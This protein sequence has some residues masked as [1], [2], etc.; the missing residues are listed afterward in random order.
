MGII[1]RVITAFKKIGLELNDAD[2]NVELV[3]QRTLQKFYRTKNNVLGYQKGN[4]VYIDN[5]YN[6]E[7]VVY[8]LAHELAHIWQVKNGLVK[9]LNRIDYWEGFADWVA[10]KIC[11][12]LGYS[13]QE[14]IILKTSLDN[15]F[16]KCLMFIYLEEHSSTKDVIS[17]VLTH[18]N[19]NK[20][21]VIL[22]LKTVAVGK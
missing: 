21:G 3:S 17:Y 4:T 6:L 19:I 7:D 14:E 20:K 13:K 18:K 10:Y 15:T 5:N 16:L 2:F 8:V 9:E 12:M 11:N 1:K 22:W